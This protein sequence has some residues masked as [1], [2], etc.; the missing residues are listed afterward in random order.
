MSAG[1]THIWLKWYY[2]I[3]SQG[4]GVCCAAARW[5]AVPSPLRGQSDQNCMSGN[6]GASLLGLSGKICIWENLL[7][8]SDTSAFVQIFNTWNCSGSTLTRAEMSAIK[9][10]CLAGAVSLDWCLISCGFAEH[11]NSQDQCHWGCSPPALHCKASPS[12]PWPFYSFSFPLLKCC[13]SVVVLHRSLLQR[14]LIDH[15]CLISCFFSSI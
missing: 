11:E 7:G 2:W 4:E 1:L 10:G 9:A 12:L 6:L 5:E 13:C 14:H 15:S 3:T 8:L